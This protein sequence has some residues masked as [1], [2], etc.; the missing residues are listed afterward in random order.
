MRQSMITEEMIQSE[1]AKTRV[2]LNRM[3]AAFAH[4]NGMGY[5]MLGAFKYN[6]INKKMTLL[7]EMLADETVAAKYA[8]NFFAFA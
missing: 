8:K 1:I 7:K 6:R 2:E 4:S 5:N 3:N